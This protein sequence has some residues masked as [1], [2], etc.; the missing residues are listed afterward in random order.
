MEGTATYQ[1]T[2]ADIHNLNLLA[3][4]SYEKFNYDASELGNNNFTT[5][6]FLYNNIEAGTGNKIVKSDATENK[7]LSYF[8]RAGYVLKGRY[9]LTATLRAD[10]ASVFAKNN[11]WGYFPSVALGWTMSEEEFLKKAEW[12]SNLKLRLRWGQTGNADIST[13]AF[14][15]Y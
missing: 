10:G 12:L 2:F 1:R 15:S 13:N 5:D 14:A 4:V 8:F 9:L 11:K 6:A 3:G 7:M